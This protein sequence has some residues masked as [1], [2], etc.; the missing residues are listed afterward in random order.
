MH[1]FRFFPQPIIETTILDIEWMSILVNT[2]DWDKPF[3]MDV[4]SL[5]ML[6]FMLN[7]SSTE[8]AN[9]KPRNILLKILFLLEEN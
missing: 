7:E 6:S 3:T 2:N 5:G 8:N 4:D 1:M 9:P